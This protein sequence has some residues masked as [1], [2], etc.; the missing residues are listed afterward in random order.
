M[1]PPHAY[2][3]LTCIVPAEP[4]LTG[5]FTPRITLP[6]GKAHAC[7]GGDATHTEALRCGAESPGPQ[8]L[9]TRTPP[10]AS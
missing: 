8:L 2:M 9:R 3:V 7:T 10:P 1:S 5:D 4:L 6:D